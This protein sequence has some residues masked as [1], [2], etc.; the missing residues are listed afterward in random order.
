MFSQYLKDIE[1]KA[2]KNQTWNCLKREVLK[3]EIEAFIKVAQE[4]FL[5]INC[6]KMK[7]HTMTNNSKCCRCS[8]RDETIDYLMNDYSKNFTS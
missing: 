2:N 3:K 1:R 7:I 8:K 5:L 4:N 6:M